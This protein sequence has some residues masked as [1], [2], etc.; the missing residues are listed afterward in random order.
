MPLS[1]EGQS[2]GGSGNELLPIMIDTHRVRRVEDFSGQ[3]FDWMDTDQWG[4]PDLAIKVFYDIDGVDVTSWSSEPSVDIYGDLN[5]TKDP[6]TGEYVSL[7]NQGGAF[8]VFEAFSA[9]DIL[10]EVSAG[11]VGIPREVLEQAA[12]QQVT[13]LRYVAREDTAADKVYFNDFDRLYPT[14]DTTDA[15][16][17][18]EDI[19]EALRDLFLDQYEDGWVKDFRPEL[20]D[21]GYSDGAKPHEATSTA[22]TTAPSTT[23]PASTSPDGGTFEPDDDL[24]F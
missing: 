10:L 18:Q 13:K 15:F 7:E 11:N 19:E 23:K 5:G 1:N 12:G 2:F 6:A 22:G 8:K 4:V 9:M 16:G 20:I 17:S 14:V 21:G 24:P 3:G